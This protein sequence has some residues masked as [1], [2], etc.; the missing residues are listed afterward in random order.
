MYESKDRDLINRCALGVI[1]H[2]QTADW[3]IDIE[4]EDA[5]KQR[6]RFLRGLEV[7]PDDEITRGW[8]LR[9]WRRQV[10]AFMVRD[11][12][13]APLPDDTYSGGVTVVTGPATGRK[14]Q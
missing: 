4:T 2:A 13:P 1:Q 14:P 8:T 5:R 11:Q 9:E 6:Y 12:T 3:A 7:I 10:Q